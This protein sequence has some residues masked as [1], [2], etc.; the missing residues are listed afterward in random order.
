MKILKQSDVD[1]LIHLHQSCQFSSAEE[2]ARSLLEDFPQELIL[3][4]ILG[5]ALEAQQ[6]FQEAADSYRHALKIQP[7]FAEM[8][9]NLGSV[10]YQLDDTLG[11]IEQYQKAIQIKPDLVVAYFNLGIAYTAN[12]PYG[13]G[14]CEQTPSSLD[15]DGG[16]CAHCRLF[17]PEVGTGEKQI[18]RIVRHVDR[19]AGNASSEYQRL[20]RIRRET[21]IYYIV[22]ES[23]LKTIR[24]HHGIPI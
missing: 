19:T 22:F 10:L 3:H 6:K 17:I 1:V 2:K 21:V 14:V 11:A 15:P 23:V 9:F 4:N 16:Y 20:R 18:Q 8:Q 7:Q 13:I 5:V 24:V 12:L